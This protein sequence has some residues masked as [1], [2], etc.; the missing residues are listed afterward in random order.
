MKSDESQ[1]LKL[2][3]NHN[4]TFFI[5]P[6]QRN[7]EWDREQCDVFLKDVIKT[8][9]T[10]SSGGDARHF[11]GSVTYFEDN[12]S[13][14]QGSYARN[15]AYKLVLIDGQQRITT[16]ML[17]LAAVRDLTNDPDDKAFIEENY[18]KNANSS[19]DT[20]YKIKLKQTETDWNVYCNIIFG[21]EPEG[22]DKYSAVYQNYLFFK[23]ELSGDRK[24]AL[25]GME[26]LEYGLEQFRVI[27][28]ELE[29]QNSWENP[30]EIFESMNSLG[31]PLSLADLVRNYLL[32]G[33]SASEQETLYK[34]YWL[35]IEKRLSKQVSDFIRD[36]MQL[37][38]QKDYLKATERNYKSLY[39]SFKDIFQNESKEALTKTFSQYSTYYAYIVKS[40]KTGNQKV[41]SK[42]ADIR[43]INITTSYSFL[44]GL[45]ASWK[46]GR[47]TD[48]DILT[49]LDVLLVYFIRRRILGLT[50]GENNNIPVLAKHIGDIERAE[51][52]K[53][54][55]YQLLSSQEKNLRVPNDD[56]V[57]Q[58][59]LEMNFSTFQYAKFIFSLVEEALTKSRPALD[60]GISMEHI[61]PQTPNAHWN[62]YLSD[63]PTVHDELVHNIGNLTLVRRNS[64]LGQKPFPEKKKIYAGREGLQ[65]TRT[66]ITNRSK[67]NRTSIRNRAKW[68]ITQILDIVL[69][70]PDEMRHANNFAPKK[71]KKPHKLSFLALSLIG[72]DIIFNK[73]RAITARVV[74]D[75]EVLFEE[76]RW[77]LSTLTREL[78]TRRGTLRPSRSYSGASSWSYN[79]YKLTDI[80]DMM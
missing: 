80:M 14:R 46:E 54:Y 5:P 51:D 48:A 36:Y 55:L 4:V 71:P 26:L 65:I 62:E 52:K 21:Q 28:I 6:Y 32:L 25:N 79:G 77:K 43:H 8:A 23:R 3:S 44:M 2:L 41:D 56:E 1:F 7:Y 37:K 11:F 15:K 66:E 27:T 31:K 74:S 16:A 34:V 29:P 75:K 12:S 50:A 57:K 22:E 13:S 42:L 40:A 68:I 38:S 10:N 69:P 76:K 63:D 60:D 19:E 78:E 72:K 33:M 49:L 39:A 47:F 70:L 67:W 58:G 59:L 64:E 9:N 24:P 17:F 53:A 73:D 61:M 18:L 20:E 45:L 35:P 30:Q